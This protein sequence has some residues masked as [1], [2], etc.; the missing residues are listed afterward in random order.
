MDDEFLVGLLRSYRSNI[1]DYYNAIFIS[2][3][4]QDLESLRSNSHALLS[5]ARA[6]FFEPLVET[7]GAIEMLSVM[8]D[9]ENIIGLMDRLAIQVKEC[10]DEID[11][12]LSKS[13]KVE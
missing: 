7:L 6:L 8:R 3:Q 5:S 13:I 2:F 11:S 4:R 9:I 12:F 1:D 10:N